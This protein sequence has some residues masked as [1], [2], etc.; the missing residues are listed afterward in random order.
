MPKDVVGGSSALRGHHVGS[1]RVNACSG[2]LSANDSATKETFLAED[3]LI[4][5]QQK[6]GLQDRLPIHCGSTS[7]VPSP[8]QLCSVVGE[9]LLHES[10]VTVPTHRLWMRL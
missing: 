6:T 8:G 7:R 2:R 4:T 5:S 10:Q 3:P 9:R 1:P